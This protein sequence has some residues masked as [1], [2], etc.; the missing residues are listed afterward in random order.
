M[1]FFLEQRGW[2][3][4]S[5]TCK[6]AVDSV[7]GDLSQFILATIIIVC[8]N[9]FN[10]IYFSPWKGLVPSLQAD[11]EYLPALCTAPENIHTHCKEG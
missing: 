8:W 6:I 5:I 1:P 4:R 3:Y 7:W 9:L 10:N 2:I 11:D